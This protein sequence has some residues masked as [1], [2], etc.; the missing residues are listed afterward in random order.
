[1]YRPAQFWC[2]LVTASHTHSLV[3]PDSLRS[4]LER[5]RTVVTGDSILCFHIVDLY[6]GKLQFRRWLELIISL[7]ANFPR[8]RLLDDWTHSFNQPVTIHTVLG[9]LGAWSTANVDDQSLSRSVWQDLTAIRGQNH[10]DP[11]DEKGPGRQIVF[12]GA[13]P[14]NLVYYIVYD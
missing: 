5:L 14:P 3:Q 7:F 6:R 1:M 9:T 8:I 12:P 11:A 4:C 13:L 10:F 2:L